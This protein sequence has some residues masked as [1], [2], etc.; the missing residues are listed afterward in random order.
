MPRVSVY[1]M[2]KLINLFRL[3]REER[4]PALCA[5]VV[6]VFL[7]VVVI[8][9][10]FELFSKTNQGHWNVFVKNFLVSGFD[11]ITYSVVTYWTPNYNVY[12]HPLLAFMVWPLSVLNTWLTELTGMN[13]VQIIVALPLLFCAFYAFI[14]MFRIFRD[15]IQINRFD[16]T[17]LAAMTF[18]FAYVM[19]AAIVPDHFCISMFL[20]VFSL[21]VC[22]L[23]IMRKEKLRIWQTVVLFFATAGV[24][25]S[26]GVKIFI[27]ALFTNG[28]RFF[29]PKFLF[30]AVLLPSALI[31]GFARWEYRTMVL[32]QEK[33][34]H[35]L[36]AKKNAEK[37][38]KL[39]E[40][41]KDTT[42]LK[43][44]I[45]IKKAFDRKLKELA[46]AKYAKDHKQPWNKNT[47]KPI[48]K[49][50]FM[51]WTDATTSRLATAIENL[52][53]ESIQLHKRFLLQDVLR[54]RPVLVPYNWVINYLVEAIIVAL[55]AWGIWCGRRSRFLWMALGGFAFDMALHMGLGFGINEV[56][57]MGAHW[58]FV[59]PLAMAFVVK[60]KEGTKAGSNIRLLLIW[61][62]TWL[63][64]YNGKLL[65]GYLL[66]S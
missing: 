60:A 9:R 17:V 49:G 45:E 10:N 27:D 7:H 35:E 62:T 43:D 8:A 40:N 50:E 47:G 3:R 15:I 11:P 13:L 19:V 55:F 59:L 29:R 33:A 4:W 23:K 34:R 38:Q 39:Y 46:M 64:V 18:S 36:A 30:L 21:Y 48:A 1:Y 22:G 5:L 16:S 24:T 41:F 37:K 25:L 65:I 56:Y 20:L 61:L 51:N 2:K 31:W 26:N 28:V 53:G 44:S 42:S 12:R 58:L 52:F 32:P 63:W 54:N 14:F 66:N 57:I 6:L